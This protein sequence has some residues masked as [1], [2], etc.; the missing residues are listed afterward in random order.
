MCAILH[1]LCQIQSTSSRSRYVNCG[2][3]HIQCIYIS[4]YSGFNIEL[5]VS[6]LLLQT[7]RHFDARYTANW[8]P[9]V[10]H[11]LQFTLCELWSRPNTMYLQLGIFRLQFSTERICADIRGISSVQCALY[12]N[13]G[14]KYS[15]DPPDYAM[16]TV[17][18]ATYNVFTAPYIQDSIFN[19]TQL[20][21]YWRYLDSAMRVTLQSFCQIQRTTSSLLYLNCSLRHIQW[22]YSSAYSGFNIQLNVSALILEICRQFSA[23]Y[24]ANFVPNTAH[25]S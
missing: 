12:C 1:S 5:N 23:P 17:F 19:W 10:A 13:L 11:M 3:G 4:I 20:C 7:R 16:W 15:A 25:I 9:N 14:A 18:P 21:C 24:T 6:T 22:N 8:V 2:P